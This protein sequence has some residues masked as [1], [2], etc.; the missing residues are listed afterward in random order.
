MTL[1]DAAALER[2]P[3]VANSAMNRDRAL[4]GANSYSKDLGE[5][6]LA[7]L[8]AAASRPGE[9]A[10]LDLCCGA[11]RALSEAARLLDADPST[12]SRVSIT[13]VD[14]VASFD[15]PRSSEKGLRILEA[16]LERWEPDETFDL[17]TC[18]HG[19]HYVGDKLG[20]IRRAL[21]WIR[22]RGVF[23]ANLD[24]A[25]VRLEG[26]RPAARLVGAAFRAGGLAWRPK[27]RVLRSDG[28]RSLDTGLEFLGANDRAGP[29]YT[30]QAA[31]N[32]YYR[33]R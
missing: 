14:L 30:G 10:W 11:G 23:L 27:A 1:Q 20:L 28:P 5:D 9:V 15:A 16:N 12:R 7:L 26:G 6:L 8:T 19:L 4:L 31:V 18:V 21:T 29:N 24:L 22:P 17:V 32:S 3:V 2:S 25:N 13:G 33:R